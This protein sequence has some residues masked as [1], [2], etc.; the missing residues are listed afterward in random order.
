MENVAGYSSKSKIAIAMNYFLKNYNE[1]TLFIKNKDLPID[2]NSQER[3]MRSPVVGRKTWYGTH[4]KRGART[5]A[6]L[7][8]LVESCKLNHVNPR[9]YFR[10]L[11]QDLHDGKAPY[12]PKDYA[13]LLK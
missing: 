7:F 11:V 6:I 9:E 13:H 3:Q 2:N 1:F 4:S 10:K 12:T 5:T 8:S